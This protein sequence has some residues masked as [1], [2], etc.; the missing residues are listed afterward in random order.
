MIKIVASKYVKKEQKEEFLKLTSEL[1]KDSRKEEG[2]ISYALYQD[3]ADQTHLTFIEEWKDD[4]AIIAH[5]K[6]KHF[7][8]IIPLLGELCY[9]DGTIEKY[10]E[11]EL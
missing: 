7:T 9:K 11:A 4:D 10:M 2:C 8:R 5:N 3:I 1:V 6:S